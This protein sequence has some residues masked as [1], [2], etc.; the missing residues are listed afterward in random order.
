MTM[1]RI[2]V[3]GLLLAVAL[4]AQAAAEIYRWTDADGRVHYGDRRAAPAA[5][6]EHRLDLAD[7]AGPPSPPPGMEPTDTVRERVR[8]RLDALERAQS[9]IVE[10]GSALALAIER[11]QRGV[12]P[13][14]GERLGMAGGASRLA[15][16]YF[17]RQAKLEKGVR[18]ARAQLDAAHAAKN[19]LR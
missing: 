4:P 9:G 13:L 14:P 5:Q 18:R 10:A 6:S 19:A 11:R 7:D 17:E 3:F 12:E 8:A 1:F 2:T 16:A 15:P